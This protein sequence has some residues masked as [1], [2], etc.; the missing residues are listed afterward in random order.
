MATR[1]VSLGD[2]LF[3]ML[4]SRRTKILTLC[5]T[6]IQLNLKRKME[7]NRPDFYKLLGLIILIT[8]FEFTTISSLWIRAP[9]SKYIPAP[10]LG[11]ATGISRP[12]FD[13]LWSAL[14]W[15]EQPKE[16]PE[17]TPHAEHWWML[18]YDMFEI[19]N[20]QREDFLP[21]EWICVDESISPWYG[22][23]VG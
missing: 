21:S 6:N 20:R 18:I 2:Y 9:I 8:R 16:I 7:M 14:Q 3:F 4:L 11:I 12:F 13:A 10:K 22:I 5:M 23:W 15:S 1:L 17:G 19:F